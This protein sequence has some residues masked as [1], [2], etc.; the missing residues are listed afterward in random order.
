[1]EISHHL[2]AALYFGIA[3]IEAYL[4]QQ[5]RKHLEPIAEDRVIAVCI[6]W[7]IKGGPPNQRGIIEFDIM[8]DDYDYTWGNAGETDEEGLGDTSVMDLQNI[9]TYEL[10]HA[11][12]LADLYCD[13]ATEQTMYGYGEAGEA[14]KRTLNTGDIEGIKKLYG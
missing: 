7:Y 5:M 8:F 9:A 10:G 2:T 14:K 3:A 13:E 6:V 12:G 4:N 11:L 1:M